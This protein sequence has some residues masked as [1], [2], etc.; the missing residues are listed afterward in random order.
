MTGVNHVILIGQIGRDMQLQESKHGR[1]V[2]L[3]GLATHTYTHDTEHSVKEKTEWHQVVAWDVLGELCAEQLKM[4]DTVWVEGHL[5]YTQQEATSHELSA[6]EAHELE[7][8][9]PAEI[10]ATSVQFIKHRDLPTKVEH[11]T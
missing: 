10:Y 2:C 4:G 11:P 8:R 9:P 3:F 1:L 5:H 6:K 7:Q